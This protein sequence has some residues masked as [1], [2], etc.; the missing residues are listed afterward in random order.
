L[1]TRPRH[2]GCEERRVERDQRSCAPRNRG[3]TG[4]NSDHAGPQY[5]D[6]ALLGTPRSRKVLARLVCR[7]RSAECHWRRDRMAAS[8]MDSHPVDYHCRASGGQFQPRIEPNTSKRQAE[9]DVVP[10]E[11]VPGHH[12]SIAYRH[13]KTQ[14]HS[15]HSKTFGSSDLPPWNEAVFWVAFFHGRVVIPTLPFFVT[16]A[17]SGRTRVCPNP[18]KRAA[19]PGRSS[20]RRAVRCTRRACGAS[21]PIIRDKQA[22]AAESSAILTLY[23]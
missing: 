11:A 2:L 1:R 21:D 8:R 5:D 20:P 4:S 6:G 14:F 9:P 22:R 16:T 10:W 12:V 18:V 13:F 23:D 3:R 19:V 7:S 15:F 17:E